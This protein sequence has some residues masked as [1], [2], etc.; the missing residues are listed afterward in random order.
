MGVADTLPLVTSPSDILHAAR[1]HAG[2]SARALAAR[3]GVPTS[4]V[5][6]IEK[7]TIDPTLG[8]L[9]RLLEAAGHDLM[10]EAVPAEEA[11]LSLASLSNAGI[12]EA[13][14][15]RIDWTRLRAFA[16]WAHL[17]PE[18]LADAL[19]EPPRRTG[20]ALDAILAG[21]AEL[22]AERAGIEPPA[23]TRSVPVPEE[24]FIPPGTPSMRARAAE[25]TPQAFRRRNIVLARSALFR[26]AA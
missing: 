5:T 16:D 23:W 2:L 25:S 10:V 6:R 7:G 26:D 17:H 12:V 1:L 8:M 4:T 19:V 18:A 3:A 13:D 20:T 14:R 11:P 21:F 24:P 15:L 9:S 22:L